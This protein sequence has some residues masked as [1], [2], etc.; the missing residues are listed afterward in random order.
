[1]GR[2]FEIGAD[3]EP[4]L[5]CG[6]Q[7]AES[8]HVVIDDHAVEGFGLQQFHER[9]VPLLPARAVRRI[10]NFRARLLPNPLRTNRQAELGQSLAVDGG[11]SPPL[12][13]QA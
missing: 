3:R 11:L 8:H 5:F 1:M 2:D 10:G 9:R 4:Q 7:S 12:A 13:A 6:G